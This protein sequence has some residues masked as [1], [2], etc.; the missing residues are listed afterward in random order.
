[1][2][3]FIP[4]YT[5][6]CE[7][8]SEAQSTLVAM[9]VD[10]QSPAKPAAKASSENTPSPAG[11]S[12]A[13]DSCTPGPRGNSHGSSSSSLS[14]SPAPHIKAIRSPPQPLSAAATAVL[15][16]N[17]AQAPARPGGLLDAMR[18]R[19]TLPGSRPVPRSPSSPAVEPHVGEPQ[20]ASPGSAGSPA[21]RK[22]LREESP[23]ALRPR[24]LPQ[25]V[26]PTAAKTKVAPMNG[27]NKDL[28]ATPATP[29]LKAKR[30]PVPAFKSELE[31]WLVLRQ[32]PL[33][34]KKP[35]DNYEISDKGSDSEEED[36]RSS[37]AIPEWSE[38]YLE[39][40]QTQSDIDADTIFGSR[41]PKC[42]LEDVF[43]DS[44]YMKFQT[45]RPP[46]R[47][48]SSGE[49]RHDSLS[50]LSEPHFSGLMVGRNLRLQAQDRAVEEVAGKSI[51]V[52]ETRSHSASGDLLSSSEAFA[53]NS[54][55]DVSPDPRHPCRWGHDPSFSQ[56]LSKLYDVAST[57][58]DSDTDPN[59]EVQDLHG[60]SCH[61]VPIDV[62]SDSEVE[63]AEPPK[64]SAPSVRSAAQ[65][66]T[67][68]LHWTAASQPGA[69]KPK[70][71][72]AREAT[73]RRRERRERASALRFWELRLP[74]PVVGYDLQVE[75]L[76]LST[77]VNGLDIHFPLE[78]LS[79]QLRVVAAA[80]AAME[81]STVA[82][83]E[84]PTGTGKTLGLQNCVGRARGFFCRKGQ[85]EK[86]SES[87]VPR[88]VWIART[89]DQLEHAIRE[90]RRLPYRPL[91]SLRISR[92]RFCLHPFVQQAQDKSTACEMATMTRN[93]N[94]LGGGQSGCVHLDNA[95][96]I[97]YPTIPEHR[98][99]FETGGKLAVY[100][101]E[102]LVKEGHETQSLGRET[103][104]YHASMDLTS[105]GAALVL[106]TY[107]QIMD[108]CV[109]ESSNFEQVLQDAVVVVDE[110]HNLPQV[111]R[112]A[113][114][115]RGGVV[116]FEQLMSKLQ[117]LA[118]ATAEQEAVQL[119]ERVCG[120]IFTTLLVGFT[121]HIFPSNPSIFFGSLPWTFAM[122]D[123]PSM[124]RRPSVRRTSIFDHQR[125]SIE[126]RLSDGG[127]MER[128]HSQPKMR[129]GPVPQVVVRNFIAEVEPNILRA[130]LKIFDPEY[131]FH[132]TSDQFCMGMEKA[133][134]AGDVYL[135]FQRL[136]TDN[137]GK[138]T[139][140]EID[141]DAAKLWLT[142]K[143]WCV[144]SFESP[145]DM[146]Y[147]LS[148]GK[149]YLSEEDF[150]L[151]C[152]LFD[153]KDG[154]EEWL[155]KG[156]AL[157]NEEYVRPE[158]LKWMALGKEEHREKEELK[159]LAMKVHAVKIRE[160][161]MLAQALPQFKA[162]LKRKCGGSLLAAWRRHL[163]RHASMSVHK[164]E[165]AKAVKA[166]CWPGEF[167]ILWKALDKD[168]SGLVS[169]QELDM[170][171]AEVL[172]EFKSFI[173]AEFGTAEDAFHAMDKA[174]NNS[175]RLSERDFIE[176]CQRHGFTATRALFRGLDFHAT[177]SI[178][179][180]EL[181][182]LDHWVCPS[183]LTAPKNEAAAQEFKH[184]MLLWRECARFNLEQEKF[185]EDPGFSGDWVHQL[186]GTAYP[187]IFRVVSVDQ[188]DT[189][190][191][192]TDC[193]AGVLSMVLV[194]TQSAALQ[195]RAG[196]KQEPIYA[197]PM[198][199][200]SNHLEQLETQVNRGADFKGDAEWGATPRVVL[201]ETDFLDPGDQEFNTSPKKEGESVGD[202]YGSVSLNDCIA[203]CNRV[204]RCM[205]IAH[206]PHG[207]HLK[208][209]CVQP[210]EDMVPQGEQG[211]DY[212]TLFRRSCSLSSTQENRY[213]EEMQNMMGMALRALE[214]CLHCL[215]ASPWPFLLE[216]VLQNYALAVE[217]PEH[218]LWQRSSGRPPSFA[219]FP[220]PSPGTEELSLEPPSSK[221]PI[222]A[223]RLTLLRLQVRW[224]R[225]LEMEADFWRGKLSLN[226]EENVS[227]ER[228]KRWLATGEVPWTLPGDDLCHY[229]QDARSR[230]GVRN[231]PR[232]LNTGS[233][234]LAPKP[235]RC[236][237][238]DVKVVAADGLAR[239]Y[240]KVLDEN[241]ME[242]PYL[243]VQCPVEEAATRGGLGECNAVSSK[244]L[245][246][247][248]PSGRF[249]TG[250]KSLQGDP[251]ER[252]A[253]LHLCFPAAH[254]D[255]VHIR[256][257]LDHSFD[258]VLGI[259]RMLQV[260]RPGGWV[261][262]RH[263]RN[264]GV[265]GKFRN[266]LHQWAFDVEDSSGEV[267]FL[268]WNP[269]L[270]ADVTNHLLSTGHAAE[271]KTR[272]L[273]HPSDDAPEDE[274]YV[275]VEIRK[276]TAEEFASHLRLKGS[277]LK[278]Q[279]KSCLKAWRTCL[280]K[281]NS[282][283]VTWER[284]QEGANRV[285]FHTDLPGAWRYLTAGSTFL[286]LHDI[287]PETA[288]RIS[289]FQA[290]ADEQFGSMMCAFKLFDLDRNGYVDVTEFTRVLIGFG[291][292]GGQ[293]KA[294][295]YCLDVD[296]H[297]RLSRRNVA[298][299]DDWARPGE[300][301][302]EELTD[303]AD[304][305]KTTQKEK[306]VE[307]SPRM[308]ELAV[309]KKPREEPKPL[310]KRMLR[311]MRGLAEKFPGK[312]ADF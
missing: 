169:Y 101:I 35:E 269:D 135:L 162:F 142:F 147:R 236:Q 14:S 133:G 222:S 274:R 182:F 56:A 38:K 296:G 44:D 91:E 185:L 226:P 276:P 190:T 253:E 93:G 99:K 79:S 20:V 227:L 203:H 312:P 16:E 189:F 283:R 244:A 118:K 90:L 204:P 282:N 152:R 157:H 75:R 259:E 24:P 45:E 284:F 54:A 98:A 205:S 292:P 233:G 145:L 107:P 279:Y 268:I 49:W 151:R 201:Q 39:L 260:T 69:K 28:K 184:R 11:G 6:W 85:D 288:D 266:G 265:P 60:Q 148:R 15:L 245:A 55:R 134:Y 211:A 125:H 255:V 165:M 164:Y 26:R 208:A 82:L 239:F 41:V 92:E 53:T 97:G 13:K 129:R 138:L 12:I 207:C 174:K 212:R 7:D 58:I 46:R 131:R 172:A 270:R 300:E 95:E 177:G 22:R 153:W 110:A 263:A 267:H 167:R 3:M 196:A 114:S 309:P 170:Q 193:P 104:P 251:K 275:W 112:D 136:D 81:K 217:A 17:L 271:V 250:T 141:E 241:E 27:A 228:L 31:P 86:E 8:A 9:A 32:M 277:G 52:C 218:F 47:R 216:E 298:F 256:N 258:P 163:D 19:G 80:A 124:L 130:W 64:L 186:C 87:P 155:W 51:A 302:C 308:L 197:E 299:I 123:E 257:A 262:L 102:D 43:K 113:A 293:C 77:N 42:D 154:Q 67:S 57:A 111:A 280:D 220:G 304:E 311:E 286:T 23:E 175:G 150:K 243:P 21:E 192:S 25:T 116:D 232:I 156:V 4:V 1:M 224:I 272:L 295:F 285:F 223:V 128:R 159:K 247:E 173:T 221:A 176:E 278:K 30:P 76:C 132:I 166:L 149:D 178:T 180:D 160:R 10:P 108:P 305:K 310:G 50:R 158:M 194:C 261:L 68:L 65:R 171:G 248:K 231:V 183:Y 143:Q 307:L 70:L 242:P 84:S 301:T 235:L 66:Q 115:F 225:G 287:D 36:D 202:F 103:C 96:A 127:A 126:R 181:L 140:D 195:H 213:M 191:L 62:G 18:Q 120:A 209:R 144:A 48:G 210:G 88:V 59:E 94:A 117:G 281:D 179:R 200:H 72:T 294:L 105:E 240:L 78:P 161:Q 188:D 121:P 5:G 290:F 289:H 264:E 254:F 139:L 33:P 199:F 119:A 89:H 297:G 71:L 230:G 29:K 234:P 198:S 61:E 252:A 238:K 37:K 273:D 73:Q 249:V 74:P 219:A 306:E 100:D 237:N 109:R 206:G 83:V 63:M 106:C 303:K 246:M 168:K 215:D 229:L 187:V 214:F 34:P 2:S 122:A 137:S 40:L 291:Y 146:V